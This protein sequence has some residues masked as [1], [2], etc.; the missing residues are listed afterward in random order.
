M[1]HVAKWE[2]FSREG[3]MPKF[4]HQP[5]RVKVSWPQS[6]GNLHGSV[7]VHLYVVL[8]PTEGIRQDWAYQHL[9]TLDFGI[10]Y[11]TRTSVYPVVKPYIDLLTVKFGLNITHVHWWTYGKLGEEVRD[12]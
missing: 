9:L 8:P 5:C 4:R 1:D 11:V 2:E 3:V 6:N 10:K 12:G 7:K